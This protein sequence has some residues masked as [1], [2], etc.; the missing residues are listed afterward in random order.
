ME[1][2]WLDERR[3]GKME[4]WNEN[5]PRPSVGETAISGDVRGRHFGWEIQTYIMLKKDT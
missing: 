5:M 1:E 2:R 4:W 3:E